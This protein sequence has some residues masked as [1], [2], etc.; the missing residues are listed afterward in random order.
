MTTSSSA[1]LYGGLS[2]RPKNGWRDIL[3]VPNLFTVPGDVLAGAALASIGA[4]ELPLIVPGILI[5]LCLYS[6]GLILN[7]YRDREKDA[8]ERPGRPIPSGRVK[9]KNALAAALM[10]LNAALLIGLPA[11]GKFHMFFSPA[12]PRLAV[13]KVIL[14]LIVLIVG[15]N[16]AARIVPWLGFGVMGMCRGAN[17][18]LGA[19]LCTQ[20]FNPLIWTAAGAEA[21]YIAFVTAAAHRETDAVPPLLARWLPSAGSAAILAALCVMA[22]PSVTGILLFLLFFGRVAYVTARKEY[23]P[24]MIGHLI[25]ALIILQAALVAAAL[26]KT[27]PEPAHYWMMIGFLAAMYYFSVQTGRTD[28]AS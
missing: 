18:L 9:P 12:V 28:N 2:Y 4:K 19:A 6:A 3:R 25:R 14:A 15:Y 10:L 7:D 11:S 23:G 27:G 8:K 26:P 5:S 17:L 21:V 13:L 24:G 1:P 22:K 16:S 20:G